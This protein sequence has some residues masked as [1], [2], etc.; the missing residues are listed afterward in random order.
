MPISFINTTIHKA[1]SNK[2]IRKFPILLVVRDT[3]YV[4]FF[5]RQKTFTDLD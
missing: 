5:L 1:Y 3:L 4:Y 2:N